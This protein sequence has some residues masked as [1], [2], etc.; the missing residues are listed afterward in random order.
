[1]GLSVTPL[2]GGT[3]SE[4]FLKCSFEGIISPLSHGWPELSGTCCHCRTFYFPLDEARLECRGS[5]RRLSTLAPRFSKFTHLDLSPDA[6]HI[7]RSEHP[8]LSHVE[9]GIVDLLRPGEPDAFP[10]GK[11]WDAVF[12]LDTLLYRGDFV[13]TALKSIR[14]FL[15]PRGIAIVDMPAQFR[16]S[17]S[18][19]IKGRRY[20]GPERKFSP[21]AAQALA[22]E[23]GYVC[24][25]TAYQYAELSVPT[26]RLLVKRG[27]T[28]CLPWPSTWMYLV[29]RATDPP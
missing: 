25:A 2:I 12:C 5:L 26:H 1:M 19:R 10:F 17:I 16:A 9:Y 27:L 3:P 13:E 4:H 14:T 28:D 20:R 21:K 18:R 11:V 6:L 22:R 7:A 15:S 8:E 23:A 24:L 29:L